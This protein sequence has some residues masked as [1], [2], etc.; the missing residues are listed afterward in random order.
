MGNRPGDGVGSEGRE[1]QVD[2][3]YQS[4]PDWAWFIEWPSSLHIVVMGGISR[5]RDDDSTQDHL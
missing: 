2:G 1:C 4:R 3:A 5:G